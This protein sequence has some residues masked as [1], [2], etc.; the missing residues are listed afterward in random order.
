[1]KIVFVSN[2][3]NH[4][5][6]PLADALFGQTKGEYTFI[7]TTPME[8][9]RKKMGWGQEEV[10]SYVKYNYTDEASRA[11]CQRLIEEADVVISGNAPYAMVQS[12]LKQG[13]L[14]FFYME[15]L[16][17]DKVPLLRMP[18][19][20]AISLQRYIPYKNFYVL[21]A[22]AYTAA[23]FSKTLAFIGKTYQWGYFPEV[24]T[25]DDLDALIEKKEKHSILW[26][27][28]L[29]PWKRPEV[30]LDVAERLKRD[31]YDFT[32]RMIGNG[33]LE[34][35]I[36]AEIQ[37]RG[38]SDCVQM[39]GSMTPE[40][41]RGYME[42]SEVF[43]FTSGKGEGWGAV[44]NESMNSGCAVVASHAIGSV[45][46]LLE[47]GENGLIYQDGNA[48]DTYQKVKFLLDHD[49][50]RR[51][52]ATKA[53]AT[54]TEEWNAKNAASKLISLCEGLLSGKKKYAPFDRGVCSPAKI[55]RDDWKK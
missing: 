51:S 31:G 5:Q 7:A 44:L 45:P 8:E 25:H 17:K 15:R 40:E 27:A 52:M 36:K 35:T 22:S 54:M 47:D 38:L 50:E 39:L 43:L 28:R 19:N 29:I 14:T 33:I 21:C 10:P 32:L 55:L 42:A 49:Q 34:E 12:R 30:A 11:E 18:L 46:F 48:E 24:K 53:Y 9:E 26:V 37:R 4:H 16:Y 23:D 3:Y 13:K 1:M 41:V 2:Y 20:F 6:K